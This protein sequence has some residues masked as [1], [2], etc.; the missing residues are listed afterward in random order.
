MRR[1]TALALIGGGTLAAVTV[2]AFARGQLGGRRPEAELQDTEGSHSMEPDNWYLQ[3]RRRIMR[4]I[5]LAMPHYRKLFVKTYG[6][7]EGE[8]IA[9]DAI[10]RFEALL[11]D[12]PYI[13]GD[14]NRLTRTLYL[15]AAMLAMYRSLM[16][17]GEST[18]GAARLIHM[19]S[20]SF[21]NAFPTRYLMRWGGRQQF[22]RKRIDQRTR[23]AAVSQERRYSGDWVFD[24]VKGDGQSFEWGLD[25]TECGIVKYLTREGA[26]ELGSYLCWLDYPV[27]ATMG[28]KLTRTETIAQGCRRCDFRFS[29]GQPV[30]VKPEFLNV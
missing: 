13:G 27:F 5:R 30:E 22:G 21:Y 8:A 26:P 1:V 11:P 4:E 9:R 29:R 3:H 15:T 10:Q 19:G 6:K 12:I 18:E 23:E 20:A 28:V 16:A 17:R 7:E 2:G 14:E 25:Y 24:V